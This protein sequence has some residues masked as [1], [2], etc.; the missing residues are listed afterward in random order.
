MAGAE[1]PSLLLRGGNAET[2]PASPVCS[3][4]M[5]SRG[6]AGS[7]TPGVWVRLLSP[8]TPAGG[9]RPTGLYLVISTTSSCKALAESRSIPNSSEAGSGFP[10]VSDSPKLSQ[11]KPPPLM[12][13]GG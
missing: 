12:A 11:S 1:A 9:A 10:L 5:V 8:H 7:R 6:Q 4:G 13:K 2:A 3:P